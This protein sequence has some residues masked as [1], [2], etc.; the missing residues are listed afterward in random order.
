MYQEEDG[1]LSTI[2]DE[3]TGQNLYWYP[4]VDQA[5]ERQKE[6]VKK[7]ME[8]RRAAGMTGEEAALARR[9]AQPL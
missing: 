5:I 3:V 7:S 9:F 4:D 6:E 8:E 2:Y 1:T